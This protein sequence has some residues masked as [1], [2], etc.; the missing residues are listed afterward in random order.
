[1]HL[2]GINL[3]I[4]D[5]KDQRVEGARVIV[6]PSLKTSPVSHDIFYSQSTRVFMLVRQVPID[7][8]VVAPGFA[9]VTFKDLAS[10]QKVVMK[11]GIPVRVRLTGGARIPEAPVYLQASLELE[12]DM[13]HQDAEARRALGMEQG[14]DPI[15]FDQTG[16][17]QVW[18]PAPGRYGVILSVAR[19]VSRVT[20]AA[21]VPHKAPVVNVGAS[22]AEV[23]IDVTPL[24]VER[25]MN[26][27]G[28]R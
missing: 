6:L 4:V 22:G 5:E 8:A 18:A 17:A 2:K 23:T 25:A 28:V 11:P 12:S 7:V 13:K 14:V 27:V 26:Q 10:D 15:A 9:R 21:A 16:L 19:K 3:T 24:A 1:M 20:T